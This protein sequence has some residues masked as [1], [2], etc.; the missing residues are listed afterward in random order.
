MKKIKKGF[1]CACAA[2]AMMALSGV[3]PLF[4][5]QNDAV[6]V[7]AVSSD[8]PM[9]L[10]NIASADNSAVLTENGTNDGSPLSVKAL[11]NNLSPSWRF[12]YVGT[13]SNGAFFKICNAESG[14]IITPDRY[15]VKSGSGVI[16]YGSES[17]KS[18]HWYVIPV[19]K[20]RLGNAL[21]YKIVNYLDTS[22][23]LT[24]GSSGITLSG[25]SGNASQHW[26]L[27]SDGLQ[28]FAGYCKNDN[29]GKVKAGDIGGLFGKAVEASSFSE[30]KT[31][32]ESDEPLTIVVTKDISVYDL[33]KNGDRY[34]CT[35][36]RIYVR[37][38][39]TIIGS[40]GAHKLYNVQFCTSSKNGT[41]NNII[42]K[43]FEM[44]HDAESNHND[45]IVCYF[46]SGENI[47][48]DHVSFTGHSN[49]GKAPKTQQVDED[50]FVACCYDADYTTISDCS[51]GEHKYG[52]ILGYP[53]DNAGNQQKYGGYP[54]MSLISNNFNGCNT[55]GPGLMRWGYFHSLNNYVNNFN[56][57]YTV[58]SD[59]NIFAENC[60]YEN[61]GNVICDWDKVS[62]VGHYSETGS[63]FNNCKRTKQGGD[64]NSTATGTSWRP[65]GN[66]S[67]TSVSAS[68]VKNYAN[69]WCG[70]KTKSEYINYLRYGQAG[71]P[72]AGRTE[73]PSAPFTSEAPVTTVPPVTTTVTTTTTTEATTTVT[74]TVTSTEPAV[75]TV[76]ETTVTAPVTTV[77]EPVKVKGDVNADGVVNIFDLINLQG[78]ILGTSN[79][80]IAD[81]EAAD[82][83]GDGFINVVDFILVKSVLAS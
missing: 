10:I 55:R 35:A 53:D 66:Y 11:G 73:S 77:T 64:S 68:Q 61:G 79:G 6:H 60:L 69:W 42:I 30:L 59:C 50:K 47:W 1:F 20:D 3:L 39:K 37:S 34:M 2:S 28:G 72:S 27:N 41:G 80:F 8:F 40:Y 83:S 12:D 23:A 62:I 57:A 38:N 4:G 44:T 82:I 63:V 54:R 65:S 75:T 36:G 48:L 78:Y 5:F 25:Y 67:Y 21:Q 17:D 19:S 31:Y 18:Q 24:Q 9:Q 16:V 33:N 29:T 56:M 58:I 45:S 76:P 51:F 22:L 13:D 32:A 52:L 14:R 70:A 49:Y 7:S 26:L 43:N 15:S 71:V 74:T 81:T 46:G